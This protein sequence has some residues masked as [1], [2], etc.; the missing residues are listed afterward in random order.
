MPP[1]LSL[2][3]PAYI[4][5]I[6]QTSDRR[7]EFGIATTRFCSAIPI[8]P[9]PGCLSQTTP[10]KREGETRFYYTGMAQAMLLD[11]LLRDRQQPTWK[12]MALSED[13]WLEMLLT[14][15]AAR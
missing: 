8:R 9:F 15:A 7:S 3:A 2:S 10:S 12:S 6:Y 11:Q 13:I 14:E 4:D 1:Q 5:R